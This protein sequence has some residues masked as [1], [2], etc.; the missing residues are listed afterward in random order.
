MTAA[1]ER[2]DYSTVARFDLTS[3]H[4]T[5]SGKVLCFRVGCFLVGSASLTDTT[6][7]ITAAM[8]FIRTG[9]P[10]T[11]TYGLSKS[12]PFSEPELKMP[13]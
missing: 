4:Q 1:H 12:T 6:E 9:M 11:D 10:L 8:S 2:R 7:Y 5:A 3:F 13:G